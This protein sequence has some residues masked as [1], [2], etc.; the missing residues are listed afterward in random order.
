M[1]DRVIDLDEDLDD[2]LLDVVEERAEKA[3]LP[4]EVYVQIAVGK[5]MLDADPD[6]DTFDEVDPD[7]AGRNILD[8][9]AERTEG[10]S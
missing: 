7:V 6:A 10:D 8:R 4:P 1:S 2:E 3:G 9:V 5:A